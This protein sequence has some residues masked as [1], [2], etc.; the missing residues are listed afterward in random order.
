LF[1]YDSNNHFKLRLLLFARMNIILLKLL[2]SI[3]ARYFLSSN[4]LQD[5]E[6]SAWMTI[7]NSKDNNACVV[8]TGFN[9]NLLKN[10]NTY[11][12]GINNPSSSQ[13]G[14]PTRLHQLDYLAM[15]L[16]WLRGKMDY[17]NLAMIFACP[18]ATISRHIW[19]II[20]KLNKKLPRLKDAEVMWPTEEKVKEYSILMKRKWNLDRV[21]GWM[22]GTD[23]RVMHPRNIKS[24]RCCS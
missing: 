17:N 11:L 20:D 13:G 2:G 15:T 18:P 6:E 3:R 14:R 10:L 19:D 9:R 12:L 24:S 4:N 22:D 21:F 1:G 7:W 5:P 8:V 23:F 16:C